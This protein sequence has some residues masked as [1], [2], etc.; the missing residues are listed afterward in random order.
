MKF[1][2]IIVAAGRGR[3]ARCTANKILIR[4][5]NIP[6]LYYSLKRFAALEECEQIILVASQDDLQEGCMDVDK[7]KRDYRIDKVVTG[8]KE[9]I[10]SVRNGF[11]QT[12]PGLPVVVVHDAARPFVTG[13]LILSVAHAAGKWGAAIAAVPAGD[14]L[15]EAGDELFVSR[16]VS[17]DNIF[18]AQTP[19]AFSREVL[20]KAYKVNAPAGVTDE[21]QLVEA[22]GMKVKIVNSLTTNIKITTPEDLQFAEKLLPI[23]EGE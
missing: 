19:Q 3:R 22:L 17:R 16:T 13:E 21:A 7:L 5:G 11:M 1:T 18:Q 8:G 2:S 20:E 9:R 23:W 6:I 12:A 4:A 14:T 10:D 15:K